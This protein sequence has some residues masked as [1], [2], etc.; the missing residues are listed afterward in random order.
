[1]AVTDDVEGAVEF[2]TKARKA[3]VK[4]ILGIEAYVAIGDRTARRQTGIADGGFHLVLLAENETG[5]R[6]LLKL[7]SDAYLNGFYYKPRIDKELLGEFN[8]GLICLS[9]CLSGEVASAMAW[10]S[11][12]RIFSIIQGP[13]MMS[14]AMAVVL[15]RTMVRASSGLTPSRSINWFIRR[16]PLIPRIKSGVE[17]ADLKV[18]K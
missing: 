14:A 13:V 17:G 4:P 18:Q 15:V 11:T 2:Y 10:S 8:E 12:P 6:N 7:S 3:G 9:G 1:M 5:W 16:R